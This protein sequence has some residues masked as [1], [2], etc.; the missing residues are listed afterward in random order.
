[1][2]WSQR[3]KIFKS[4]CPKCTV[5][6]DSV[7]CLPSWIF[8]CPLTKGLDILVGL[9]RSLGGTEQEF[10]CSFSRLV[11]VV[12][13]CCSVFMHAA[14]VGHTRNYSGNLRRPVASNLEFLLNIQTIWTPDSFSYKS[15]PTFVICRRC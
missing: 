4:S 1:M 7:F 15:G 11:S 10:G 13:V 12:W 6:A 5:S 14:N 9:G 2:C 8:H 3:L